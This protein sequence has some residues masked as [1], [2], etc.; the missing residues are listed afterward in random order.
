M[1][2]FFQPSIKILESSI[3]ISKCFLCCTL[4]YFINPWKLRFLNSI[5]FSTLFKEIRKS[6]L[7]FFCII[8]LNSLL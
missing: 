8:L 5:Q 7:A 2:P 1:L 3:E 6:I 4:R